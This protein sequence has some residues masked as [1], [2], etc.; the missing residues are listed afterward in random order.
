MKVRCID[1]SGGGG[2]GITV[3]KVY[4]VEASPLTSTYL[5]FYTVMRNDN[6]NKCPY[7]KR[8]FEAVEE[9]AVVCA[10]VKNGNTKFRL[11]L[12]REY[13]V[14]KE[15]SGFFLINNDVGI[16]V[17]YPKSAFILYEKETTP[18]KDEIE[19]TLPSKMVIKGTHDQVQYALNSMGLGYLMPKPRYD[20]N[21]W[22]KSGSKGWIRIKEM[23]TAHLRNAILKRYR[24]WVD[25]LSSITNPQE[26]CL[27]MDTGLMPDNT[28]V[29]MVTEYSKRSEP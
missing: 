11:T 12:G 25:G 10:R 20:P 8:R 2:R 16:D 22:Y 13:K 14:L 3:G 1:N 29:A 4:E 6:G 17:Y 23:N 24:E 5:D 15:T 27:A 9:K 7:F 21:F 28:W 18:V 19:V 26:L